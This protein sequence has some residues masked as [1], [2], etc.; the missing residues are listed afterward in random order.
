MKVLVA[1][2]R[3]RSDAPSGENIVVDHE[4]DVLRANGVDIVPLIRESDSIAGLSAMNKIGVVLGP[5]RNPQG[6]HDFRELLASQRPDVVHVHNVYPLLSPWIVRE[7]KAQNIPVVMTVHNF[8]LD[9]VAGTY[10]R[11]GKVCTECAGL[12]IALP[13]LRHGCYRGSHLQSV[14][15]VVGRSVHK[16]TWASVDRF[17]ALTSFHAQYLRQ[18]GIAEDHIVIRPTSVADPGEPSPPGRD[19]LFVGRLGPEKGVDTLLDAW[20]RS[21]ASGNGRLLHLVG[22]GELR[23]R[24]EQAAAL[25]TS[26]RVHGQLSAEGVKTLM[27]SCGPVVIPST[28]FEGLPRVLVEALAMGRPPLVSSIGGLEAIVTEAI[29]WQSPA[30]HAIELAA[31]LSALDD[32]AIA[33]K[34]LAARAAY[35]REFDERVT[36]PQL[37]NVYTELAPAA[38]TS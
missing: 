14:P 25:D 15:M 4:I 20:S 3:Y 34:G 8:R 36:T 17:L 5:V 2:N 1:H 10:L 6:V 9:C 24:A 26:I 18:I 30:G 31:A 28:W 27:N 37:M 23:S 33:T 38:L 12:T 29:G 32:A 13:A 16:R 35:L 19:F 11:D 7:A 22:D 21:S